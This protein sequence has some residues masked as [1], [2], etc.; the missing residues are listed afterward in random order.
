MDERLVDAAFLGNGLRVT[1]DAAEG[2]DGDRHR[3]VAQ[4]RIGLIVYS[5]EHMAAV[6]ICLAPRVVTGGNERDDGGEKSSNSLPETTSTV[7]FPPKP[8]R[9]A[10]LWVLILTSRS[11]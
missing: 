8:P 7:R 1:E 10:R 5:D 9:S 6:P 2:V 3:V 11:A 4:S